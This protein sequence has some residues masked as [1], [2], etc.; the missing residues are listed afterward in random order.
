MHVVL[1]YPT[2]LTSNVK[3]LYTRGLHDWAKLRKRL[4]RRFKK[5]QYVQ[6]WERTRKGYPHCHMAVTC[7]RMYYCM[8]TDGILNWWEWLRVDATQCGFGKIGWCKPITRGPAMAKYLANLCAEVTGTGKAYQ[9]P[10]NAPKG[11][12]RLRA[13]VGLLPPVHKNPDITGSLWFCDRNGEV[14]EKNNVPSAAQKKGGMDAARPGHSRPPS[15]SQT[16]AS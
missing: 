12:R 2:W 8:G 4:H 9:I 11:F 14:L 3:D 13:S 1:T 6:V 15:L 5:M 10:T 7:E 16:Q